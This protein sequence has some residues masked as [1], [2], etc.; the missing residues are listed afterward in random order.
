MEH[1]VYFWLKDGR[2]NAADRAE[3][4]KALADLFEMDLVTGGRWAVPAKVE[5]R[6]VVDQSWDYALSMQF[7]SLEDHNEYQTHPSHKAFIE[8]YREWWAKVLVT[9]LA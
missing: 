5:I 9:D 3:F 4:E 8:D 6:P 1:H 2:Q 7:A